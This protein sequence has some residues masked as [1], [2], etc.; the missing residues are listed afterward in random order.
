MNC[1]QQRQSPRRSGPSCPRRRCRKRVASR[2]R[3]PLWPRPRPKLRLRSSRPT[4]SRWTISGITSLVLDHMCLPARMMP[5]DG[6]LI[7]FYSV[8]V[9]SSCR[10]SHVVNKAISSQHLHETPPSFCTQAVAAGERGP[11]EEGHNGVIRHPG[12]DARAQP[13]RV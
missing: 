4:R 10:M 2:Q 12:T 7:S 1:R 8:P 9:L 6:S 13:G 3:T 5:H 11:A